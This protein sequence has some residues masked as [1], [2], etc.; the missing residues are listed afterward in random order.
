MTAENLTL[1]PELLDAVRRISGTEHLLVALDFDGTLSP[2]LVDH[3]ED[4]RPPCPPGPPLH[5]RPWQNCHARRRHSSR[6]AHWTVCGWSPR[7]RWIR[8]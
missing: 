8:C 4:A 5:W 1:S 6:A 3:A 2:P 7:L